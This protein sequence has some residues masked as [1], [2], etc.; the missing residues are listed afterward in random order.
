[1]KKVLYLFVF[2][3]LVLCH[4]LLL[5]A[6]QSCTLHISTPGTLWD[7]LPDNIFE[8]ITELTITGTLNSTDARYVRSVCGGNEK[9]FSDPSIL[10]KIDLSGVTFVKGGEYYAEFRE[11]EN[12]LRKYYIER[13]DE[14]PDKLFYNCT[15]IEEIILPNNVKAIGVGAFFNC[16]ELKKITIP[17]QVTEIRSTAF[18]VCRTLETIKLPSAL[19]SLGAYMFI[20]CKALKEVTIPEGVKRFNTCMFQESMVERVY[21]PQTMEFIAPEC[22]MG[23]GELREIVVPEGIEEIGNYVFYAC[24]KLEKVQLPNS[25]KEIQNCAFQDCP[26]LEKINFPEGLTKIGSLA[27]FNCKSIKEVS[28]PSTLKEVQM[29]AFRNCEA[30]SVCNLG[31]GVERIG[32]L[33]F[34]HCMGIEKLEIPASM[35]YLESSAFAECMGLKEVKIHATDMQFVSNPFWGCLNLE[36]YVVAEDNPKFM[37]YKGGL[38]SKDGRFLYSF[39]NMSSQVCAMHPNTE[40]T[41]NYAIWYCRN[42]KEIHI[43]KNFNTFGKRAFCGSENVKKITIEVPTPILYDIE[44]DPFEGIDLPNCELWVPKGSKEAYLASDLWNKFKISEFTAINA[45]DK[46]ECRVRVLPSMISIDH[47]DSAYQTATLW[48]MV[49]NRIAEASVENGTV[50][51]ATVAL[52]SGCYM[53]VLKGSSATEVVK[54]VLP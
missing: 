30:L 10:K 22:F 19:T 33:A 14:I 37:E 34:L 41:D 36:R 53:L 16:Y 28:F 48:D 12:S 13:S 32:E 46:A 39:A 49:G 20:Y 6:Q 52:P 35:E 23:A 21:L 43:P 3:A 25:L 44:S 18:G 31:T 4:S 42:L 5:R 9:G 2:C 17:D 27:F 7:K 40:E 29:E 24:W 47:V 26:K 54:V 45:I 15:S 51:F 50:S 38:Y 1:M 8:D 11:E